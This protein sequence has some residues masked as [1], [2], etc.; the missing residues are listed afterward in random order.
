MTH[1]K[2]AA[3]FALLQG[4]A[5][6][7]ETFTYNLN[8]GELYPDDMTPEKEKQLIEDGKSETAGRLDLDEEETD[9]QE[10]E[11]EGASDE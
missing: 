2:I 4:Q 7:W 8:R 6:S 1:E 3:L 10:E 5:M 11:E 9:E